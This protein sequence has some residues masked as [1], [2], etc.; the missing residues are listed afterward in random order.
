MCGVDGSIIF[1]S[2]RSGDLE[3]WRMDADGKNLKQLTNQPGYD[4]GAF[5]SKDCS[6]IVW[7]S[8]R[9]QG[10]D[11]EDYKALLAQ[12]LVKPTKMDLYVANADG[13]D[14]RQVTYLTGPRSRRTS[15]LT[16]SGSSSR[17]TI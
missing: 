1:T 6:K 7:R 11:L 2:I 12:H 5:F 3:L 8:S 4:G 10:K 15:F 14:A 9:P 16:A 17:R 13:S